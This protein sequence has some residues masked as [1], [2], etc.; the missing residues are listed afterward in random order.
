MRRG[1]L[2]LLLAGALLAAAAAATAPAAGT[3]AREV[4]VMTFN[5]ASAAFTGND[6]EVLSDAISSEDPDIVGL[7]EVDNS[8]SRSDSVN[9]AAGIAAQLGMNYVFAPFYD[10]ASRDVDGDGFCQYGVALMTRFPIVPGS[11]ERVSLPRADLGET[12]GLLRALIDVHG[13]QVQ[14]LVTHLAIEQPSR[15]LQVPAIVRF[16]NSHAG[17]TIMVCDCNAT[18]GAPELRLLRKRLVDSQQLAELP[19]RTARGGRVD[20]VYVSKQ[21]GVLGARLGPVGYSDHR[22]LVAELRLPR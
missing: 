18:A 5:I 19:G 8:W 15:M 9:Q 6:L 11:I 20:Y 22:P 3:S 13:R 4:D 21:I 14:V 1:V 12:R 7:E 2:S 10:C 16:L 17:T